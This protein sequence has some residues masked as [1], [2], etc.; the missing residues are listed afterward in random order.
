M[1]EIN[2]PWEVTTGVEGGDYVTTIRKIRVE[3]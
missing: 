2:R 3:M 1:A